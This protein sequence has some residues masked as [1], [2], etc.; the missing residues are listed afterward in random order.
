VAMICVETSRKK[1]RGGGDGLLAGTSKIICFYFFLYV[2]VCRYSP[3][4]PNKA[5]FL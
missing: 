1:G 3:K 5:H 4:P 2:F